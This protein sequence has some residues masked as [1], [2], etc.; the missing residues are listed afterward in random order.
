MKKNILFLLVLTAAQTAHAAVWEK[1]LQPASGQM[2][3]AVAPDLKNPGRILVA[4][5]DG[6]FSGMENG[7]WEKIRGG[8]APRQVR[9]I[10]CFPQV[11]DSIFLLS[12]EG[13]FECSLKE[14]ECRQ[15]LRASK[16]VS[17]APLSMAMDP[18]DAEHW[19]LGTQKGLLESDDRGRTWFPFSNFR[20]EAVPVLRFSQNHLFVAA[21]NSLF[22]SKD[23]A[24]FRRVFSVP[25]TEAG[26]TG[27]EEVFSEEAPFTQASGLYQ[28]VSAEGKNTLWLSASSGI[29][30][31]MDKGLSW[32]AMPAAGL[33]DF[34]AFQLEYSDKTKSL[35]AG[36]RHG[37]FA[38]D[39]DDGAWRKIYAGLEKE[40]ALGMALVKSET[41][42]TLA[43]ITRA[44][45]FFYPIF[46]DQVRPAD[47]GANGDSLLL[48]QK[49]VR[50]E[51]SMGEVQRHAVRYANVLNGKIKRWHAE[52][53]MAAVL[54]SLYFGKDFDLSNNVDIDR[55]GTSDPDK[56]IQGPLDKSRSWNAHVSWNFAD[57]LF[58]SN[59]T[60]IDSREKLMVELRND[61]LA[62]VTRIYYER[63][64]LQMDLIF[65]PGGTEQEHLEK[66]M[67]VEELTSLLDGFTGN[68]FSRRLE[69]IYGADPELQALW[70]YREIKE[71]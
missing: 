29:F 16:S 41:K 62:E 52:S 64:R 49:L 24:H 36:T 12:D 48:F 69:K 33:Q 65:N 63:R 10:L 39:P 19:F 2:L 25:K 27:E 56:F 60:S 4:S 57:F 32:Q 5:G 11:P 35:F 21:G 26:E 68:Y 40:E 53:R 6:L 31:S 45:F 67:R 71:A 34:K 1:P 43:C 14:N 9:R 3:Q 28:M 42:E 54:P 30:K 44:G 15:F 7:P 17:P 58:S 61:I 37:V 46:P 50:M 20:T 13:A 47:G 8:H 22:R 18:E 51:P 59:Q 66:I 38:F 55:G 23:R 70:D